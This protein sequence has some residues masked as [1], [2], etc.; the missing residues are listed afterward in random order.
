MTLAEMTLADM[1]LVEMTLAGMT[2]AGITLARMVSNAPTATCLA[3]KKQIA[4]GRRNTNVLRGSQM[5][6]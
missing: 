1:T 2:L 3:T 5:Q 6:P 4:E